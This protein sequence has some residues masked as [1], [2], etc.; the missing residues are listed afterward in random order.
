MAHLDIK[1]TEE[2]CN[3]VFTNFT[4]K[5]FPHFNNKVKKLV[6]ELHEN[7]RVEA[8]LSLFNIYIKEVLY[9]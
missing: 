5:Q 3:L 4:N 9:I 8:W 2:E 1:H 7:Q 6:I